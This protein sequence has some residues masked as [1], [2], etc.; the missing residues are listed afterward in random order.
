M[1]MPD[2]SVIIPT[3]NEGEHLR[4]TLYQLRATI[5]P[6]VD[7][8]VVDD[9]AADGCCD[10]LR[11]GGENVRLLEF[12]GARLGVSG[13]RNRGAQAA[14]GE[15]L[16]FLDAHVELPPGWIEAL[17]DAASAPGVGAVAPA[18]SVLGRPE[19]CSWGMR[20][21]DAE[22][23]IEW[24]PAPKQ[25]QPA[26]VPMVPGCC[27]AMRREVFESIGGFDPGLRQWGSEDDELCL[28]LWTAGYEVRIVPDVAVAHLFRPS[29][30]YQ[31][32]WSAILHNKM[33]VAFVHFGPARIARVVERLKRFGDFAAACALIAGSDVSDRRGAVRAARQFDDD[34]YFA[35]FGDFQ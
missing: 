14:K 4:R 28:R 2:L 20:Y 6:G 22:L 15:T 8:I 7:V 35:R 18:I 1:P 24:L 32:D 21:R 27:I 16:V 11:D 12:S 10:F 34:T 9:G 5:A 33:R 26:A 19:C 25:R 3:L 30:P 29:H 31:V 23:A 17:R 13:A